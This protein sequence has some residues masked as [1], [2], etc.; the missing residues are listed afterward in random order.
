V[1]PAAGGELEIGG[2]RVRVTNLEKVLWPATGTTKGDVLRWYVDVAPVLLPH[3]EGR[4]LTLVR[5]PDGVEGPGWYQTRCRGEPP[6][7]TVA[8]LPGREGVVRFCV[9]NDLASLVWVVNLATIELHVYLARM[10]RP[11]VPTTMIFDLDPGPPAGLVDCCRVALLVRDALEGVGLRAFPKASGASGLH[12]HVPLNGDAPY[13]EVKA[14]ARAVAGA[15][16]RERPGLV[17]DRQGPANRVGRVLIDW[18]QNDAWRSTIAPYSLRGT[19]RP[20]VA[21]PLMWDEVE[22]AAATGDARP[23]LPDPDEARRRLDRHGDLMA[24]VLGLRQPLPLGAGAGG[25]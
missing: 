1:T 10:E 19:P 6:W 24:P 2:R 5:L 16:A 18:R 4:P 7:V 8:E 25:G 20:L 13:P 23:L 21:A 22:R 14:F 15:L 11:D 9:A 17:V 3:L 12:V